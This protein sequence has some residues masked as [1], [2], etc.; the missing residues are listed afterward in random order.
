MKTQLEETNKM[1]KF[2]GLPILVEQ[3]EDPKIDRGEKEKTDQEDILQKHKIEKKKN[4]GGVDCDGEKGGSAY[5]DSCDECVGGNTGKEDCKGGPIAEVEGDG[6]EGGGEPA[7]DEVTNNAV[8]EG[9]DC[10]E[11]DSWGVSHEE[12]EKNEKNKLGE[13]SEGRETYHYGED[14]GEDREEEEHLEHEEEMAPADRIKE[15]E[16]HLD[17]LK[18]DMGYDEDHEDRDE[19]GTNFAEQKKIRTNKK[20]IKLTEGDLNNVVNRVIR[21]DKKQKSYGKIR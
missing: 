4:P 21:E 19:E 1:R 16:R 10:R 12:W 5:I 20:I 14:E 2:M 17:A 11:H 9:H 18:K 13:D 15:I 7:D 8:D 6:E 3:E